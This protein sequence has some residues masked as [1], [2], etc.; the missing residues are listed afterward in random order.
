MNAAEHD[1]FWSLYESQVRPAIERTCTAVSRSKTDS[2]MDIDDMVAWIDTKVWRMLKNDQSP[3]FHDDPSV[4]V[5]IDRLVTHASTLANWAYLGLCRK[6]F[7]RLNN[8]SQYLKNMSQ[9]QRLAM[10]S[11]VDTQIQ[12]RK[13]LDEAISSLRESLSA[14]EKQKLAAS[15][16]EKSDRQRIAL[17]LGATRREDD[18]M[19][20]K[21]SGGGMNENA[22][23]QMR[24]RAR[25]R[26]SQI[27]RNARKLPFYMIASLVVLTVSL[28][29]NQ[30]T[31]GEQTGGRKGMSFSQSHSVAMDLGG[32]IPGEQSGG[33]KPK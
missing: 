30:A 14:N 8:S 1:R 12:D 29:A 9:A 33:R 5:S 3:T 21:T 25:K 20:T 11:A 18:R 15:W 13:D 16:I 26:A 23:Q 7:R 31:A 4:E 22:V 24:S 32:V 28:S 10:T 2:T 19:I 6:H 17:V 27:L